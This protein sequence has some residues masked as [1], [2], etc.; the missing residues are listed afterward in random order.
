MTDLRNIDSELATI[1]D[2]NLT[3][4]SL[5]GNQIYNGKTNHAILMHAIRYIDILKIQKV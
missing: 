2:Q 5:Y 1:T 3:N 4:I